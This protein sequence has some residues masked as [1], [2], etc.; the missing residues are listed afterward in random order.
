VD[1]RRFDEMARA[2]AGTA[3]GSR[4]RLVRGMLG[5]ALAAVALGRGS[6]AGAQTASV[7]PGGVCASTDDCLQAAGELTVVCGDNGIASDGALN[8]CRNAGGACGG[9]AGCCGSLECIAGVCGGGGA[10]PAA[11][12]DP[13][14]SVAALPIGSPCTSVSQCLPSTSG[15]VLC[16]S[17]T[18]AADGE[19]NCCLT[20]GGQCG[21][22][23]AFCCGDL[24]CVEGVCSA[25]DVV[26]GDVGPGGV[27]AGHV[28]CSQA[29][30]PAVCE[31]GACCRLEVSSCAS[32][33][34]CCGDL[35]CGDNQLA[36]D[37]AL[38]CC[39]NLGGPCLSDAACCG[40]NYCIEGTCQALA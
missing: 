40:D 20:E 5:A 22:F 3:P 12:T 32:D 17:N 14:G 18:I 13:G 16:A 15:T 1:G 4:R 25:Q 34:E 23:D 30:G 27:C 36:E 2:L 6:R 21:G 24:L 19:F 26:F 39:S 9:G 31:A 7:P 28:D 38:T 11:P 10:A 29:G 33:A 8:C 37:G 35:I